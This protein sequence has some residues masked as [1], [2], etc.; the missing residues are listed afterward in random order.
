MK[1]DSSNVFSLA[2]RKI[3]VTGAAGH[4]GKA[5]CEYLVSDGATVFAVDIDD[6]G[7]K[8]LDS[9]PGAIDS[10]V[11]LGVDLANERD[12]VALGEM[13]REHTEH[14]DG[15]VFSAAFV[16]TSA[17]DGWAVDFEYQ[18]LG[19]WREAIEVNLIAPFH[20]TQIFEPLL[21]RG[22]NSSVV[23]IGSI[24]GSLA[25]D[26]SLYEGTALKNP[27]AYGAS[28]A[29]LAQLTRWLS[30]ELAPSVRVNTVSPGG[31]LRG[32][33]RE[34][35]ERYIDKTPLRRMAS[36]SDVVPQVAFLLSSAASYITGQE[37]FVDGGFSSQ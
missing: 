23:N 32:Q 20:L 27:S 9:L 17:L 29:G 12:R 31:I 25:P 8:A 19:A 33:P 14:L 11:T 1:V 18:T 5:I 3:L 10:L 28:K 6:A 36:E 24:Y 35:V 2:K 26:W 4:L 34:F 13:V 30:A 15:A 22:R 37:V 21:K 7:L 16:G